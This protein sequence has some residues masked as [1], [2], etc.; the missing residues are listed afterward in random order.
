MSAKTL[1]LIVLFCLGLGLFLV[2]GRSVKNNIVSPVSDGSNNFYMENFSISNFTED[3]VLSRVISGQ[4]MTRETESGASKII[5]PQAILYRDAKAA[6]KIVSAEGMIS[7]DQTL[8]NLSK[9]VRAR[10]Q[11]NEDLEIQTNQLD[12]NLSS[13]IAQTDDKVTIMHPTGY[14]EGIGMSAELS[15][16]EMRLNSQV[17]GHYAQPQ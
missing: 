15:K 1:L 12:I 4:Q 13:Q 17:K 6:W 16:N 7:S 2:S 11:P 14:Q 9:T 10:M 3:G 8:L 5:N